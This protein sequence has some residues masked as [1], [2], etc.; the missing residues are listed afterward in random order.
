LRKVARGLCVLLG[1]FVLLPLLSCVP[2]STGELTV[3]DDFRKIPGITQA[4]IEAIEKIQENYSSFT[5]AMM[6]PNTE[7]FYDENGE[8]KGFSALL[9]EWLTDVF[10]IPFVPIFKDWPET[11]SGLADHSIDFT[12]EITATPERREFLY[13]TDSIGERTIKAIRHIGS[14]SIAES[15]AENPVRCCFLKGTTAFDCVEPYASNIEA[16]YAESLSEVLTFFDEG[17]ID[18]FVV[19]GTAEAVFDT[20][21]SI[22]AED[23]SPIIYSPVSLS[24]QNPDLIPIIDVVQKVLVSE[25]SYL[26]P[27]MYEQGYTEYLRRK[28]SLRLTPEEKAYL[29]EHI[30]TNTPI[31]YIAEFDNYPISFFNARTGQW[32]GVAHDILREISKI[33]GLTFE[34]VNEPGTAWVDMLPLLRSGEA[35][36]VTELIYS[37][38]REGSYIWSE[39]PYC[40]DN[41][42]LLSTSE[43]ADVGVS[44]ISRIRVGLLKSGAYSDFFY[45]RFPDHKNVVEYARTLDAVSALER[46]EVDL[47]MATR[48]ILLHITNYLEKPGFKANL[49]FMRTTSSYY[50]FNVNERIVC[51][52]VSK[53][54][55]LVETH[56]ILDRWQRTVFD[57]KSAL[58]RERMP[59]WIGLVVLVLFII[60]LLVIL[61][62]RNK[63]AGVLLEA[64][65]RERTRELEIQTQTS[66]A[67]LDFNPFCSVLF[68][69]DMNILD[70]NLSARDFFGLEEVIVSKEYFFHRLRTMVPEFQPNGRKSMPFTDRLRTTF[71]TGSCAFETTLIVENQQYCF[72]ITMKR[73]MYQDK[74]AAIAYMFD[75]TAQ[76][77]IQSELAYHDHLLEAL[78]DVANLLLTADAKDLDLTMHTAMDLIGRAASVDRVYIWKN[79]TGEDKRLYASQ[80][81]EWSPD[82]EPQHGNELSAGISYDD[83]MTSWKAVLQKGQT[84]NVFSKD[85]TPEEKTLLVPQG[86]VSVLLVP[87]FL[88]DN[89][90]G[91]IGFDDCHDER[92]FSD[93]EENVLR[94]CGFM[95]MVINDTIQNEVAMYL[96]AERE[97]ALIS[98]Q[99]KS[100]FL[101]NMSHEIRTPMNAILGMT[102]LILHESTTD[103]V[104]AY[105][106]DIRNACRGLLAIINDILDISKIESGK[107]EIIPTRYQ[108]SSMLMDVISIIK[109]RVDKKAI[110]FV[111]NIDAS[112]PSE[113]YGDE[114][115]IRQILINLLSNAVKFT[116]EGQITLAVSHQMDG[117]ACQLTFT[118]SD[119]GIG[120][121][122]EDKQKVFVLFQQVNTRKNRDIEGT[123]LGLS[124]SKQLAEMMGGYIGMESEYGVGS[125]FT[126]VVQQGVS[127]RKPIAA[128][129][130]PERGTVLVYES[131]SAYLNSLT[132]ALDS[133]GCSYKVCTNRMEIHARLDDYACEYIFI[134]SLYI[135]VIREVA[136]QK[137]PNAVII[138]LNGDGNPYLSM[139]LLSI[140]MPIHCLQIANILNDEYAGNEIR[141][142]GAPSANIIASE[143]K[144]LVVDDNIVNLKVA[145][146]LLNIY[147]I[148]ADTAANGMRALEMVR[149]K[150]YD[151]I[152]MD[153]MMPGMDGIDTTYAIRNLGEKYATVPIV[154]LTANAVSG[155]KEMLK[156]EGLDDFLPKPI[157]MS[158]LDA[159]LKRWLP[160][161][162]QQVKMER[163]TSE[164]E[165]YC[166]ING[167]DVRKGVNNSG[168]SLESYRE[169]LAVYAMDSESR[170][171]EMAKYHKEGDIRALTIYAHALKS[172]SAN[173]GADDV[174]GMAEEIEAAGKEGDTLYIDANLR[175]FADT[176]SAL[177][178]DIHNY[179]CGIQHD[180]IVP[181]KLADL[182]YLKHALAEMER[183]MGGL[184]IDAVEG[185]LKE[186]HEY[187]WDDA[188]SAGIARIRE[189]A[190]VFDY[191]GAEAAIGM[192]K[193]K[194]QI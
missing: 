168:G 193:T 191:D 188:T 111:V 43:Y 150:D 78:G 166:E 115:R 11:L 93:V 18:C 42:V 13:M 63:R 39:E 173:I 172:A 60:S 102:E 33:S 134:S 54:Q 85:A 136:M 99:T 1:L 186:L 132:F 12:G 90:W 86:I 89:F 53:T 98:A 83:T 66:R 50:G 183:H 77:R 182:A 151:I 154:A 80:I 62:I 127:S 141:I 189:C 179:L 5:M 114:M 91:F 158:K 35:A 69:E 110:S 187:H 147:K 184:D 64:T 146:G 190:G 107:L 46:G 119:T 22:I 106:T 143:A 74:V 52:I 38:E 59:M 167:L 48:N 118:V 29:H 103:A 101:A 105:A 170:L 68:D 26:F 124:I 24:T 135:D 6:P 129:K 84:V 97:A 194:L 174:S 4:E 51:S 123:G 139:N 160:S 142:G 41:Y 128:L 164:E 47:L 20:D 82:V 126:A 28:L 7:L 116:Q 100:N 57:Y 71:E 67:V 120:I 32:E 15:T 157:E 104:F 17:K 21:S 72:N 56:T 161:E 3:L 108:I 180:D 96:L 163:M 125:T 140:T 169:L 58:A 117:D 133:L 37:K 88:Q 149:E 81:F 181:D 19:D 137:H 70:Y 9:C 130:H 131:R 27:Q 121:K 144:V 31:P 8:I 122:E 148:Q 92:V 155:V 16:I 95:T 171:L 175:L 14:K 30:Q 162:K 44:E 76:K 10:E 176:L 61:V 55:R 152:F 73:V 145:L 2:A 185:L 178:S 65:V 25:Y 40:T 153:H 113:L 23:F 138:V 87:I 75:L 45:E 192:L 79:Y 94:I 36:M 156:A 159:I 109:T 165:V 49:V 34:P 177:L 112:L